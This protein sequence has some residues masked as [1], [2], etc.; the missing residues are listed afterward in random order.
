[1]LSVAVYF[2]LIVF[3]LPD[4]YLSNE[5]LTPQPNF[6]INQSDREISLGT[7]FRIDIVSENIGE[8]GDIHILSTAFP[9]LETL[10]GIVD[11]VT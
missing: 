7:S 1:M 4:A 5:Q 3:V 9:T 2:S 8:Y 6:Q 11:I 10:D